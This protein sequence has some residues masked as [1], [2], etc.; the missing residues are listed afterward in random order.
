V[1]DEQSNRQSLGKGTVAVFENDSE[2][3][4]RRGSNYKKVNAASHIDDG[5]KQ[6]RTDTDIWEVGSTF[7]QEPNNI[8][9]FY[10]I[11]LAAD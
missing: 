5:E 8:D 6:W 10:N 9:Y 2:K 1:D 3:I 7:W 4:Q 11:W